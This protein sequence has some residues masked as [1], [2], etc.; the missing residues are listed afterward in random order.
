[1]NRPITWDLRPWPCL[2]RGPMLGF[3]TSE[4]RLAKLEAHIGK[5]RA[6]LVD[7]RKQLAKA[8]TDQWV[9]HGSVG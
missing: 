8:Q 7:L 4:D 9:V 1:M 6:E 2:P 3:M 5:V